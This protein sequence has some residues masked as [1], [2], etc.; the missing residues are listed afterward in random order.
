MAD[1]MNYVTISKMPR[2]TSAAGF[3][4]WKYSFEHYL[5]GNNGKLWRSI[6][7]GPTRITRISDDAAKTVVDKREDEY[8]DAD[9]DLVDIDAQDLAAINLALSLDI[10]QGFRNYKSAKDLWQAL[11]EVYEGNENM[12]QS[13]RDLL[14]QQF[15]LFNYIPDETLDNRFNVSTS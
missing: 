10:S 4:D 6:V 5:K 3:T 1:Q 2:L 15:N 11:H 8:T 12:R 9:F 14:C 7:K 13:R